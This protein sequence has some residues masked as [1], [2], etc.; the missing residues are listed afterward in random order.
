MSTKNLTKKLE[1][2]LREFTGDSTSAPKPRRPSDNQHESGNSYSHSRSLKH[3]TGDP[4]PTRPSEHH[5]ES[6]R[7]LSHSHSHNHRKEV[8]GH[9]PS[10]RSKAQPLPSQQNSSHNAEDYDLDLKSVWFTTWPPSFPPRTMKADGKLEWIPAIEQLGHTTRV[11]RVHVLHTDTL[12]STKIRLTWDVSNP[13]RTVKAEQRHH[14]PK[15]LSKAE[16]R[17]CRERYTKPSA[18][19]KG[20]LTQADIR[21]P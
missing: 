5:H 14:T 9:S 2:L 17:S 8:P 16:L 15:K 21:V 12:I 4:N 20:M 6:S 18:Y 7:T 13:A 1:E 10:H 19:L 3:R 11:L